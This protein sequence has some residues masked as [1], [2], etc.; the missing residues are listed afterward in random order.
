MSYLCRTHSQ[1]KQ[2]ITLYQLNDGDGHSI[3]QRRISRYK[4]IEMQIYL[5]LYRHASKYFTL[6]RSDVAPLRSALEH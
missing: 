2:I 5:S 4:K 1:N 6:H 3:S